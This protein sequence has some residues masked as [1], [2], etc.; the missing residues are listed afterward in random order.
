MIPVLEKQERELDD[1]FDSIG[2]IEVF[3]VT[4][5]VKSDYKAALASLDKKKTDALGISLLG[6]HVDVEFRMPE[7]TFEYIKVPEARDGWNRSGGG[8]WIPN[9][10]ALPPPGEADYQKRNNQPEEQLTYQN[11]FSY[12]I[13]GT[14]NNIKGSIY[15]IITLS[16]PELIR[17]YIMTKINKLSPI[18][19]E[20]SN[21]V[22]FGLDGGPVE[23]IEM[24]F[25]DRLEIVVDS[26]NR[27]IAMRRRTE[28]ESNDFYA[29]LRKGLI[30]PGDPIVPLGGKPL[31]SVDQLEWTNDGLV[32]AIKKETGGRLV[33]PDEFEKIDPFYENTSG[34]MNRLLHG[35][36]GR[37]IDIGEFRRNYPRR[38]LSKLIYDTA[39]MGVKDRIIGKDVFGNPVRVI[40]VPGGYTNFNLGIAADAIMLMISG[41]FN[42]KIFDFFADIYKKAGLTKEATRVLATE[43]ARFGVPEKE[44]VYR[45]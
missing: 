13:G 40:Y 6:E 10:G 18:T 19:N 11:L 33:R 4:S 12:M 16:A 37:G 39:A 36:P 8:I 38:I 24:D 44:P 31:T 15:R 34:A 30:K 14:I 32:E 43:Y 2:N 27:I 26:Q 21:Y 20:L 3:P 9:G 7:K 22:L 5:F 1:S 45:S 25:K 42:H 23:R 35:D 17:D 29:W 41:Y 28:R